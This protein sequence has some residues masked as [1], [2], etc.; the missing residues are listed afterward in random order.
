MKRLLLAGLLAAAP[1]A[2]SAQDR[3]VRAPAFSWT[4]VY[5]G[6]VGGFGLGTSTHSYESKNT[7]YSHGGADV[8]GGLLGG[9]LGFNY[10]IESFVLGLEARLFSTGGSGRGDAGELG[11]ETVRAPRKKSARR[12]AH[13]QRP[14]HK[15]KRRSQ[16]NTHASDSTS[17]TADVTVR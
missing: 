3:S 7:W 17:P 13:Q 10:Q 16:P 8:D 4:G 11:A 2:A 12:R 15:E 5:A 9:T 1:M 6:V 14:V